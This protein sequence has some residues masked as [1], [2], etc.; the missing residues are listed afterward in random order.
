VRGAAAATDIERRRHFGND[1]LRARGTN[2]HFGGEFHAVGA[3]IERQ[4]RSAPEATQPATKIS[5]WRA[6]Q[7]PPDPT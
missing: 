7:Q 6:E 4:N 3:Q 5:D 1:Q 2:H